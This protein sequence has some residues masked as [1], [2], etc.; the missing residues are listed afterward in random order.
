MI[1]NLVNWC[2]FCCWVFVLMM[3]CD[4]CLLCSY[5]GSG[6]SGGF[7]GGCRYGLFGCGLGCVFYCYILV[8]FGLLDT[9]VRLCGFGLI[10]L[11]LALCLLFGRC[12]LFYC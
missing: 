2:L 7:V 11:G 5:F 6:L 1:A 4:C 12:L 9:L 10:V 3:F 8:G